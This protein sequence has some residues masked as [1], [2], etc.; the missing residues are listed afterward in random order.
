MQLFVDQQLAKHTFTNAPTIKTIKFTVADVPVRI[1]T[2][3][4]GTPMGWGNDTNVVRK[5]GDL[6]HRVFVDGNLVPMFSERIV[7]RKR[8]A[9]LPKKITIYKW[10][11]ILE[12]ITGGL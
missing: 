12:L 5:G 6:R 4:Y 9:W 11:Q 8:P 10:N 7:G 3:D 1:E 2:F